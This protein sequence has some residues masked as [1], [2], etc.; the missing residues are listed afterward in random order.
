M[1]DY[2]TQNSSNACKCGQA[3]NGGQCDPLCEH[4]PGTTRQQDVNSKYEGGSE[5]TKDIVN[6]LWYKY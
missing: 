4:R 1:R 6:Q 5:C 2:A 3:S